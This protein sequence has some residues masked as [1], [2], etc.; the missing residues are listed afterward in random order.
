MIS[1]SNAKRERARRVFRNSM[2]DFRWWA[3][4]VWRIAP[5]RRERGFIP[6]VFNPIQEKV[7]RAWGKKNA[8]PKPRRIGASTMGISDVAHDTMT[9]G[10]VDSLVIGNKKEVA[11]NLLDILN[12]GYAAMPDFVEI[13]FE[14]ER[15]KFPCKPKV[16]N[17][18]KLEFRAILDWE[19]KHPKMISKVQLATAK[20]EHSVGRSL[21]IGKLLITEAGMPEYWD[22]QAFYSASQGLPEDES[23]SITVEG[24]PF[25]ATGFFYR[26][27]KQAERRANDYVYH[28]HTWMEHPAYRRKPKPDESLHPQ[29]DFEHELLNKYGASIEQMIWARYR[30]KN[31]FAEGKS[32]PFKLFHQEFPCDSYRCWLRQGRGYWGPEMITWGLERAQE[33]FKILEAA[34]RLKRYNLR[35]ATYGQPGFELDP[36]G[37]WT[38][39][40]V[41]IPGYPYLVTADPAEGLDDSD[42]SAAML[43]KPSSVGPHQCI[44][45]FSRVITVP[46]FEE[47]L[48]AA[49]RFFNWAVV[50]AEANNAGLA[51]NTLLD[52]D[53]YPNIY[54]MAGG[55]R[56]L[57]SDKRDKRY[58]FW[59][60]PDS[61]PIALGCLTRGLNDSYTS[62][63]IRL[64]GLEIPFPEVWEQFRNFSHLTSTRVGGADAPDDF[65]SCSW[66]AAWELLEG[67]SIEAP[68]QDIVRADLYLKPGD[69]IPPS[70]ITSFFPEKKFH[71]RRRFA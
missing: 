66:I 53:G 34:G 23:G 15:Y 6:L 2:L 65:V 49:G 45:I 40:E 22:G 50:A 1:A 67:G 18:S 10:N 24:S 56:G 32:D 46:D 31:Y 63:G 37:P 3:Q 70:R 61:K 16:K 5:N 62:G 68:H 52:R 59:T 42:E 12:K 36:G 29:N 57:L 69:P 51:I 41:P 48:F 30:I 71:R 8:W 39:T 14:G 13:E 44:G 9:L 54:R 11:I 26:L 64:A 43:W 38:F 20:G 17:E 58:G 25:G 55:A 28:W 33:R 21:S 35:K 27:V 47:H 7:F 60:G 19:E 4:H